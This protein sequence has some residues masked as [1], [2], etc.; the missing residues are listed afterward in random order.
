MSDAPATLTGRR[1]RPARGVAALPSAPVVA[2]VGLRARLLGAT[3]SDRLWGWLAPLIVTAVGGFLRF[4]KL[5]QPHQLVFDETYYVKQGYSYLKVG[6]ELAWNGSGKDMDALFTKGNLNVFKGDPD[7]VV[8][9][10]VGKWMIAFGEWLFGPDSSWGWRF[11]AAVVGTLSI[12]MIGRIARRLFG[13]TLLGTTAALLLAVD[14]QA[15]VHSRTALLD[16]F[17]MFWALAG[18]GC[19]VLDRDRTRERLARRIEAGAPM[20]VFGPT[21]WWRPWRLAGVV[22][23]AL[24]AGVKWSGAFF[25]AGFLL[26]S[27]LWDVGARRAIRARRWFSGAL[28]L[29]ALPAAVVALPLAVATYLASWVGWFRSTNAWDRQWG[30]QHPAPTWGWVP[31][32]LRSLWHYHAEMWNFNVTLH[33]PHPYQSNPW[34]WTLLGRPTAFFYEG[35][36]NGQGACHAVA[37]C[38]KAITP[39]G[40]PVIWWGATVGIAVL[41]VCWALGRDWRAGAVLAGLAAGW[42]PWFHWQDRTIYT[43]YA[44]A[45]VPWVVLTVTY[46]LGLLI[47]PRDASR[48]RRLY[49][50]IAAGT[51]VVLAVALFAWFYP[52]Y[53]AQLIPQPSWA[54]RM[55]LPSWV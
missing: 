17:V 11:S 35:S 51:I 55:W 29:D 40:N 39:I 37:S 26:M 52:I 33:S 41:L 44:V 25:L 43:F 2:T 5:D 32:S 36:K 27:V 28:L 22:C 47:G 1:L 16:G 3:A 49:G 6:Y 12:L 53:T 21:L 34:S 14:G 46:C 9:P 10:P 7:F 18:F 24:C 13:S 19:L 38:S 30:V 42:L 45:F 31:A 8:H 4:W 23:L 54:D 48:E 20:G 50:G 15:F